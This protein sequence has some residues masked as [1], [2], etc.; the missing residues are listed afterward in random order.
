MWSAARATAYDK[1]TFIQTQGSKVLMFRV[2]STTCALTASLPEMA[3]LHNETGLIET[4]GPPNRIWTAHCRKLSASRG[5]MGA[6]GHVVFDADVQVKKD[7]SA[8]LIASLLLISSMPLQPANPIKW[9]NG[10]AHPGVTNHAPFVSFRVTRPPGINPYRQHFAAKLSLTGT[11][12]Q[13]HGSLV[14]SKHLLDGHSP[15]ISANRVHSPPSAY[16][17]RNSLSC[18]GQCLEDCFLSFWLGEGGK[19]REGTCTH[20]TGLHLEYFLQQFDRYGRTQ[21]SGRQVRMYLYQCTSRHYKNL[22]DRPLFY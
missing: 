2:P 9:A 22:L 17:E 7:T 19:K 18:R 3:V 12:T 13:L 6:T 11:S 5:R 8:C 10:N 21:R 1:T 14:K 16:A 20:Y 4:S 15:S